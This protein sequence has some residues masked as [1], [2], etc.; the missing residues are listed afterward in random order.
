MLWREEAFVVNVYL[1]GRLQVA[2][3]PAC[4]ESG[5]VYYSCAILPATQLHPWLLWWIFLPSLP[6]PCTHRFH[7]HHSLL[8][9]NMT[10]PPQHLPRQALPQHPALH[11]NILLLRPTMDQPTSTIPTEVAGDVRAF[12]RG[13]AV[14]LEMRRG[15][16]GEV[17]EHGGDAEGGGGLATAGDA[18]ADVDFE[19]R[20]GKS[21]EGDGGALAGG[22]HCCWW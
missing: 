11:T 7:I 15:R 21:R 9:P 19:G 10:C 6:Y 5:D 17:G 3:N 2:T 20:G 4:S 16:D 22:L 8:A 14:G 12:V 1:L 18:M 13:E